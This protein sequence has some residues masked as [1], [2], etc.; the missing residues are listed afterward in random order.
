MRCRFDAVL[1]D[2][3]GTLVDTAPDLAAAL[4]AVLANRDREPPDYR[5]VRARVSWGS[6][7]LIRWAFDLDRDDPEIEDL[8]REFLDYY[9]D[10][11]CVASRLFPGIEELLRSLGRCRAA[12]GIVT[13]KYERYTTPLMRGLQPT[14]PPAVVVAGDTLPWSK[15]HP[16]PLLHACRA[17]GVA[18]HRAVYVGDDRRDVTCGRRAGVHT[19]AVGYGYNPPGEDPRAFGAGTFVEC[20]DALAGTLLR[21]E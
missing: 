15:P 8:R 21:E 4:N 5:D 1:F 19:V 13:N 20:S 6:D 3:D 2:L 18:P 9:G 16:G 14:P 7:A 17:L 12:W 11:P 10:H